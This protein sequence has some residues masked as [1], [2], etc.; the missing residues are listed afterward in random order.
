MEAFRP[1]D[2]TSFKASIP[3]SVRDLVDVKT[4]LRSDVHMTRQVKFRVQIR[5][6]KV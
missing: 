2:G 4:P 3:T 5:S 6:L 1:S